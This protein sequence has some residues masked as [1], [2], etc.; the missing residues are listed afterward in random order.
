ANSR[1]RTCARTSTSRSGRCAT[2]ASIRGSSS[3]PSSTGPSCSH[4]RRADPA[5]PPG[6]VPNRFPHYVRKPRRPSGTEGERAMDAWLGQYCINVSDL[7]ATVKFYETLGLTNTSR[8]D[9][10]NAREAIVE[11]GGGKGGKVQLAQ[12]HDHTGPI[13]HGNAFWKLY[14]NTNDIDRLYR[15]AIDAGYESTM[16]PMRMEQWPTT[17]AFVNDPDGYNVEFVQ[18][19]PWLDGDET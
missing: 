6:L 7:D 12:Q 18:R 19:H 3:T 13:D 1:V 10:P 14:I 8:T 2:S 17:V 15:A 11:D 4:A 16:E 5:H 9:I